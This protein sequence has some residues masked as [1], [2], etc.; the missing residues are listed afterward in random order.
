MYIYW[1]LLLIICCISLFMVSGNQERIKVYVSE[2]NLKPQNWFNDYLISEHISQDF[3]AKRINKTD[4][5]RFTNVFFYNQT[6]DLSESEIQYLKSKNLKLP[7]I[8]AKNITW[9]IKKPSKY[10]RSF[11]M[12]LPQRYKLY[13]KYQIPYQDLFPVFIRNQTL[14]KLS[15]SNQLSLYTPKSIQDIKNSGFILEI[16]ASAYNSRLEYFGSLFPED[17]PLGRIGSAFEIFHDIIT[18]KKLYWRDNLIWQHPD[19]LKA[20]VSLPSSDIIIN[21]TINKISEIF[22]AGLHCYFIVEIPDSR[23]NYIDVLKQKFNAR[24]EPKITGFDLTNNKSVD[25]S[26]VPWTKIHVDF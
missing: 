6:F 12:C 25:L 2:S 23:Q 1:L 5:N 7:V 11:D 16:F 19:K 14:C 10:I 18:Q 4:L 20:T 21:N 26:V 24:T 15:N 17:E 8:S 13:K 22:D 9:Q 3:H